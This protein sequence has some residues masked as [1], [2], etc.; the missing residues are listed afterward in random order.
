MLARHLWLRRG[1]ALNRHWIN[2]SRVLICSGSN[3]ILYYIILYYIILYYIIL[4]YIILYYII[5]YYIILYY[6]ILYYII[7]YY[8]ILYYIILYYII[9]YYIIL[10][11]II[12]GPNIKTCLLA[13]WIW[14]SEPYHRKSFHGVTKH[15]LR[16]S[17]QL[18]QRLTV[19]W[20]WW[21][22]RGK[23]LTRRSILDKFWLFLTVLF[24][25][26]ASCSECLCGW[27]YMPLRI[28]CMRFDSGSKGDSA[29]ASIRKASI[30]RKKSGD[31]I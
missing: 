25:E 8:I 6:I 14:A 13:G 17:S 19:V 1:P 29:N 18:I 4:Y 27:G 24:S 3:V 30:E 20:R 5:L 15:F 7:L 11:Y 28:I 16:N 12:S 10:Y 9:L 2:I 22:H 23:L 31:H 26:S 21:I